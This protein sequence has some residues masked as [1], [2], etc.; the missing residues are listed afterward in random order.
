MAFAPAEGSIAV[1]FQV[2]KES[3]QKLHASLLRL[4][5]D[6]HDAPESQ[7]CADEIGRL[8]MWNIETGAIEGQLDYALRRSSRLYDGVLELLRDLAEMSAE[9]E[10]YNL[11]IGFFAHI[12]IA[13]TIS[14][15]KVVHVTE[16]NAERSYI[17][18]ISE[19]DNSASSE[20][21][22]SFSF[23]SS[24]LCSPLHQKISEIREIVTCLVRQISALQDPTPHDT[25][26]SVTYEGADFVDQSH[27]QN[28]FP[29]ADLD[30]LNRLGTANWKRRQQLWNLH[31]RN[32]EPMRESAR[33]EGTDTPNEHGE[34]N[35]VLQAD[36]S[37][38][39]RDYVMTQGSETTH[40]ESVFSRQGSLLGTSLT[41]VTNRSKWK[42]DENSRHP[43]A[44]ENHRLELPRPPPPCSLFSGQQFKCPFCFHDLIEISSF[45]S[46]K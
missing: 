32:E 3:L 8:G 22:S 25:R 14:S 13:I 5:P 16:E 15:G 12:V 31:S 39:N 7:R 18:D 28:K 45:A 1:T 24:E 40:Q 41:S 17:P 29:K 2:C 30:L 26:T 27:M 35:P 34:S 43:V 11:R 23:G 38:Y 9:G 36:V 10:Q 46:W 19:K 37:T 20:T 6:A 33:M 4:S 42:P 21:G 44:A